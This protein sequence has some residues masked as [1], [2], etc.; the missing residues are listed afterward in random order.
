MRRKRGTEVID[1]YENLPG[2]EY[3]MGDRPKQKRSQGRGENARERGGKGRG[4]TGLLRQSTITLWKK[5]IST[6]EQ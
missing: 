3:R 2:D 5:E 6:R 1:S 4:N